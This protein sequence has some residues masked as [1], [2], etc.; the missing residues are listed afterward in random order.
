MKSKVKSLIIFYEPQ[1]LKILK[2]GETLIYHKFVTQDHPTIKHRHYRVSPIVQ[3]PMH[4][5]INKLL[6]EK[7]VEV[8]SSD[9]SSP[10]VMVKKTNSTYR[11]F[12]F[13]EDILDKLQ[14][15]RYIIMIYQ[16]VPLK[17]SRR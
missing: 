11:M 3:V 8:S 4:K 7:I 12:P 2:S 15:A 1:S 5:R 10:V 16:E 9:R 6:E 14:A 13:M 17:D